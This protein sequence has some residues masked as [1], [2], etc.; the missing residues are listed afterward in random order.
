MSKHTVTRILP[1]AFKRLAAIKHKYPN[2]KHSALVGEV[3]KEST[4]LTPFDNIKGVV[5][6]SKAIRI[7]SDQLE[8]LKAQSAV[9]G[10]T[11]IQVLS[12]KIHQL[13]DNLGV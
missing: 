7:T 1:E 12:T 4:G 10:C 8:L 3:L 11:M 9:T 2:V 13:A 5:E 6:G